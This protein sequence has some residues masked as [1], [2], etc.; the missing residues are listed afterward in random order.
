MA[1]ERGYTLHEVGWPQDVRIWPCSSLV[2]WTHFVLWDAAR[3]ELRQTLPAHYTKEALVGLIG[4]EVT[5]GLVEKALSELQVRGLIT[6]TQDGRIQ[7]NGVR[8]H[9]R[10]ITGWKDL[11]NE[12]FEQ[13]RIPTNPNE[14]RCGFGCGCGTGETT[15][16]ADAAAP[17]TEPEAA[18]ID[19][20]RIMAWW[21]QIAADLDLP[22][23]TCLTD[24]RRRWVRLKITKDPAFADLA[25]L[26][27]AIREQ[28]FLR[29][30]RDDDPSKDNGGTW[31]LSFDSLFERQDLAQRIIERRYSRRSKP[32]SDD[33]P[34]FRA[35]RKEAGDGR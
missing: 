33:M 12:G 22:R 2:K 23:I 10:K 20:Q 11:D 14:P 15:P 21:N 4:G 7:I 19:H 25:A 26:E 1:G 28:P 5:V 13:V 31:V 27:T 17:A 34:T 35:N 16:L 18:R 9:H 3:R 6:L 32:K 24:K 8:D 30:K 29:G